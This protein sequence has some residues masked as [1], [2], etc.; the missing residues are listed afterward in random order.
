MKQNYFEV[1]VRSATYNHAP[2]I[3]D[4]L[5]GFTMQETNFPYVCC[6]MDDASTDGEPEII[7][8][9]LQDNFNLEE[10]SVVRNE[11]TDDYVLCFAQHKTNK[12]CYFAVLWLK[13]NH[14]SIKKDKLPYIAEWHDK[15]QYIA[16]CEGDD[17]W[18]HP[19]KLQ[20]QVD[21]L[22]KNE[23]YG[24]VYTNYYERIG[25]TIQNGKFKPVYNIEDCLLKKGFIPTPTTLYRTSI[26]LQCDFSTKFLLGDVPIWAQIMHVSKIKRL[27][28]ITTVYRILPESA[29]HSRDYEK[30]QKFIISTWEAR[31]Y[32]ADKYALTDI[33]RQ[34][35]K[36]IIKSKALL[37][38]YQ[39]KY[40]DYLRIK[41]WKYGILNMKTLL[42][43]IQKRL[44]NTKK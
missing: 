10:E 21:F 38:L 43:I 11:E 26:Y 39:G 28:D 3:V 14:Y 36:Q 8:K 17:Y 19:R 12:N 33:S 15:A 27:I 35:G 13:Y 29:S 30:R 41:P 16:I 2:Y 23:E 42:M 18:I 5:N 34:L 25:D 32:F 6:I 4:T 1:C 22:E 7:R 44:Q 31:K 9:Y 24:M 40:M 20:M 37:A